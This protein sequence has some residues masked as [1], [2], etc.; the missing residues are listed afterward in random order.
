MAS[1]GANN[2]GTLFHVDADGTDFSVA[3]HFSDS[4]GYAPE[5]TL[6]LANNG[7]L[8]GTTNLGSTGRTTLPAWAA[9]FSLYSFTNAM[10]LMP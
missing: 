9:V 5:G 7:K 8:Y 10:M 6:C 3:Y 4:S 2:K 1:G